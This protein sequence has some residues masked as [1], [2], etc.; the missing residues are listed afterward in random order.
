MTPTATGKSQL[1]DRTPHR[2]FTALLTS[3]SASV[4]RR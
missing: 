4:L 2:L 3:E 1:D